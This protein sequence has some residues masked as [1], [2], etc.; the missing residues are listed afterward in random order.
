MDINAY[1]GE[2]QTRN[3]YSFFF[4]FSNFQSSSS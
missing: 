3:I 4:K 2:K 1:N